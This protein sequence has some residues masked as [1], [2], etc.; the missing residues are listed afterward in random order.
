MIIN[1]FFPDPIALNRNDHRAMKVKLPGKDFRFCKSIMTVPVVI[2]EFFELAVDFPILLAADGQG[3]L[4]PIALLGLKSG[5][6]LFVDGEG[7]W[8]AGYLPAA[9][10]SHPFGLFESEQE[11]GQWFSVIDKS[12]LDEVDGIALFSEEGE[13]SPELSRANTLLMAFMNDRERTAAFVTHLQALNLIKETTLQ[14]V[15]EA[16]EPIS[17]NG[18]HVIDEA[19]FNALPA[20]DVASLHVKGHLGPCYALLLS[21]R[22]VQKLLRKSLLA[23]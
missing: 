11:K 10:R 8:K 13:S 20:D 5:Q 16:A 1:T 6:N 9:L 21:M 7:Q 17:I 22:N 14:L 12:A 15:P 4:S 2:G 3:Q 23:Q 19:R 18:C